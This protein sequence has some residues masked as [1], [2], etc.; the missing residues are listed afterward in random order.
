M[1]RLWIEWR[2]DSKTTRVRDVV[3]G[4][5]TQRHPAREVQFQGQNRGASAL[6]TRWEGRKRE[7]RHPEWLLQTLTQPGPSCHLFSL[8]PKKV[9]IRSSDRQPRLVCC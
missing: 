4:H 9:L 8:M 1:V 6:P 7:E 3:L 5:R 2:G